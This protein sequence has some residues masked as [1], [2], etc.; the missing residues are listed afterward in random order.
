MKKLV[1]GI[2]SLILGVDAGVTA[3]ISIVKNLP[4]EGPWIS[5]IFQYHPPFPGH[6]LLMV[7]LIFAFLLLVIVGIFLTI[8]SARDY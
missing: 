5:N 8:A 6:G 1:F 3:C 2:L 7:V 4:A